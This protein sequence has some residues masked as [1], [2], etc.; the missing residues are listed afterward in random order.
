MCC[1]QL[2]LLHIPAVIIHG[3]TLLLQT[4]SHWYTPAYI[5]GGWAW[6]QNTA[7][8][9]QATKSILSGDAESE[10]TPQFDIELKVNQDGQLSL[11]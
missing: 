8:V 9:A 6:K 3:N 2:S 7:E 11:F 1:L 4:W 10:S 5:L